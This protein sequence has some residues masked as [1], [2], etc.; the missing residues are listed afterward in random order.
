VKEW[1]IIEGKRGILMKVL[2]RVAELNVTK[3]RVTAVISV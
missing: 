3:Q 2:F 1:D